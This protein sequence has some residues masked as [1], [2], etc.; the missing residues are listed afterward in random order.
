MTERWKAYEWQKVVQ[1]KERGFTYE[2]IA[3]Q[4]GRTKDEI[5]S[6]YLYETM[7]PARK[8]KRLERQQAKRQTY[9]ENQRTAYLTG[10]T[11]THRASPDVLLERELR[12]ATPRSITGV[13]FGDPVPGWSALD[14]RGA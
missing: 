4:L 6:K 2:A 10:P 9:T 12:L 5:K 8:L 3:V 7:A 13:V 14:R 1:L 11:P